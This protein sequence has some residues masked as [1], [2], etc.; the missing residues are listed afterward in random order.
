MEPHLWSCMHACMNSRSSKFRLQDDAWHLGILK[1]G[2]NSAQRA[3]RRRR[4][5]KQIDTKP[6]GPPFIW[7]P[8]P[9]NFRD[10]SNYRTPE[11]MQRQFYWLL[12]CSTKSTMQKYFEI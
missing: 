8:W 1:T 9:S 10:P 5:P 12:S 11:P 4:S 7:Q 3:K 2:Y 6:Q